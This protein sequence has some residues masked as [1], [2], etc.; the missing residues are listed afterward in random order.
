M[1]CEPE[2][3]KLSGQ[4]ASSTDWSSL[5]SSVIYTQAPQ[6]RRALLAQFAAAAAVRAGSYD[7]LR[8]LDH[9]LQS[10]GSGL[11]D[12][13]M[14]YP[15]SYTS[16]RGRVSSWC[17]LPAPTVC[18]GAED[19]AELRVWGMV[20]ARGWGRLRGGAAKRRGGWR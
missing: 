8:A 1:Q 11:K 20:G 2:P 3:A 19:G 13:T 18:R 15:C 6:S 10:I 4:A 12:R 16:R 17:G 5:V 7:Y 9:L 14:R